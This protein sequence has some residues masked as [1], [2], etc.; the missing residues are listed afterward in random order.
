MKAIAEKTHI[1]RVRSR[2]EH[3]LEEVCE[4]LAWT[5][6]QYCWHQYQQYERFVRN[7]CF[8][9]PDLLEWIRYSATFR[10]FWNNEWAARTD[11]NF[12]PFA[13]DCKYDVEMITEEYLHLNDAI[14]LIHDEGFY[15]R[16]ENILKL[17]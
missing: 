10:G 15:N 17:I 12:M 14:R 9:K 5:P 16:F 1:A 3:Q 2:N 4:L 8:N 11:Q 6:E 7:L 13:Y